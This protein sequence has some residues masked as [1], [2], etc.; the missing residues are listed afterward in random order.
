L[1]NTVTLLSLINK[2]FLTRD[3]L[4]CDINKLAQL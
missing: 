3:E 4:Q 2:E 1:P